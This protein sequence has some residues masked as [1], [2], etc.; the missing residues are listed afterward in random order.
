MSDASIGYGSQYAI[1]DGSTYVPLAE[2]YNIEP[3]QFESDDVDVTHMA[4]PNRTREVIPGLINPGN[5]TIDMNFVP[6]SPADQRVRELLVSGE[7][8]S[9]R[10]TY[11]NGTTETFTA[12]V[13]GYA[14]AVPNEDKMT[15]TVTMRVTGFS[16]MA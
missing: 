13:K 10:I 15:A 16:T 5:V 12:S 7:K 9:H 3:P 1:H 6:N 8:L 14:P 2:V 4:S 11:P